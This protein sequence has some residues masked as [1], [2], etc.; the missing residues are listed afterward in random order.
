MKKS[1][2][3]ALS[4]I[5]TTLAIISFVIESLFPP[6]IFAGARIGVSNV[7]ILLSLIMLGEGY[8]F[9]T[10]ILKTVIGSLFAGNVSMLIYSLPSG[11]IALAVEILLLRIVKSSV[12]SASTVGAV[13]NSICQNLTFCLMTS[14]VEVLYYL[15]Y[16]A[17]IATLAGV[18][19]GLAVFFI[20]KRLP[21]KFTEKKENLNNGEQSF[22][23]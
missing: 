19:V 6:I 8:A 23:N 1:F 18:T 16:L 5:L 4:G 17:I 15:P 20:I 11:V 12:I 3:L 10:L 22:E 14:T 2:K 13:I 9:I 21:K 7:F